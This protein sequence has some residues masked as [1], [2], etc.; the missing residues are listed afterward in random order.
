MD[1]DRSNWVK[2]ENGKFICPECENEVEP[3]TNT[4]DGIVKADLNEVTKD[5]T[6][7]PTKIIYAIC[8][9][10]GMEYEFKLVDGELWL[11]PSEEEK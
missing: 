10:C 4:V 8:P 9:V 11:K 7:Q 2:I 5:L 6:D 1:E 3:E